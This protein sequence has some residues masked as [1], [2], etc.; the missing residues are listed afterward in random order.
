MGANVWGDFQIS[1][2]VPLSGF[3]QQ[4]DGYTL[5][6]PF[7]VTF[8]NAYM[9]NLENNKNVV[10]TQSLLSANCSYNP[11]LRVESFYCVC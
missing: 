6:G 10:D 3:Y 7:S 5:G 9:L 11:N 4:T 8:S 2:S 1:I